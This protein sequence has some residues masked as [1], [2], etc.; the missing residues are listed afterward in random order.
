MPSLSHEALL[1]LFRSRPDLVPSL[2]RDAL[3]VELPAYEEVRVE[4]SDLTQTAPTAYHADLVVLLV[5]DKPVFGVVL[6]VQLA[7]KERKRFTWPMYVAGI[8][9]RLE[10]NACLLA[11]AP[12][13]EVARWAAEPIQLGPG[14]MM[15]PLVLGPESVPVVTDADAARQLPELAVLSAVAHAKGD[16]ALASEIAL[17][18]ILASLDLPDERALLYS[19]WI[20]SALSEAAR[21]ALEELM[22][23]RNYEFQSDFAR[24]YVAQG[25]AAGKAEDILTILEERGIPIQ[26]DERERILGTTELEVLNAWVRRAVTV[27]S[28]E[29]LF[30]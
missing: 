7:R 3:S 28:A 17:A 4:S 19:D 27:S 26:T 25:R 16:P 10:C 23:L 22:D 11:V 30:R 29:D 6:E 13:A 15:Q 1:L 12:T 14:G 24:K 18:A 20:R 9:A 5:N 8:R 2:L 21:T